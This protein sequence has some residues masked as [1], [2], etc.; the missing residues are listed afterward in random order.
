MGDLIPGHHRTGFVHL[1]PPAAPTDLMVVSVEDGIFNLAWNP[2]T[3]PTTTS[4]GIF[5]GTVAG[6]EGL[7]P[8]ATTTGNTIDLTG[9]AIGGMYFFTVKAL[10]T[11]GYGQASN[12]A[13]VDTS[14]GYSYAGFLPTL[15]PQANQVQ[16]LTQYDTG[17]FAGTYTLTQTGGGQAFPSFWFPNSYGT[18]NQFMYANFIYGMDTYP[19]T[20]NGVNGTVYANPYM[21]HATPMIWEV[22]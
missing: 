19:L 1:M 13:S 16:A 4:Y 5:V 10:N 14:V 21:T 20:I 18:P 7:T 22:S 8:Y 3:D 17:V 11:S 9:L 15:T 6:G 12:E 2:S